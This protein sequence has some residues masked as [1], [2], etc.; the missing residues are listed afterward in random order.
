MS[1]A[2][3]LTVARAAAVPFVVALF[4]ISSRTT[5]TG[6]RAC[7]CAA[8]A[9]DWFDG[10]LA[11]RTRPDLVA[12]LAARPGGGQAARAGDADRPDRRGR[13]PGLDGRGDRRA[14]TAD[15]GPAPAALERGVVIAARDLGKLKTWSQAVAAAVGGLAAAG[16]WSDGGRLVGA[17]RRARADLGLGLDYARAAPQRPPRPRRPP[18]TAGDVER[19][20]AVE[21]RTRRRTRAQEPEVVGGPVEPAL[22]LGAAAKVQWMQYGRSGGVSYSWQR[23]HITHVQR[24]RPPGGYVSSDSWSPASHHGVARPRAPADLRDGRDELR[25]RFPGPERGQLDVHDSQ[26]I[27][28]SGDAQ[29]LDSRD[30]A[31]QSGFSP[32]RVIPPSP[33]V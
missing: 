27:R 16:A 19:R 20:A 30:S 14:R 31:P 28:L 25:P 33:R 6:R 3:Q 10:R 13:L 26:R 11:R 18:P 5:T 21:R 32:L 1:F 7:S 23:M 15:L 17:A 4:A 2:D 22:D 9:T 29:S 12:R 24:E 8:M